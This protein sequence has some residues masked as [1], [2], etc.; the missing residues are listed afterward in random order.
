MDLHIVRTQ[1]KQTLESREMTQEAFAR[2]YDLSSSWLNKFLR[3]EVTDPRISSVERL[4]K[5]IDA[6]TL[7]AS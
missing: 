5:A 7:R 1:L 4:Q 2:K 6:E 3:E